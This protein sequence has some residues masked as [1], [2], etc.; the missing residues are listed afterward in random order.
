MSK[1]SN[2][3]DV[4]VTQLKNDISILSVRIF[5]AKEERDDIG[6]DELHEL[7]SH[8]REVADRVDDW[9]SAKNS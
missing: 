3:S 7:S 5:Q 4:I 1:L 2:V 9:A 6:S 8:L